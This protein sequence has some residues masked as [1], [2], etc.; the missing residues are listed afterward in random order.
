MQSKLTTD[1]ETVIVSLCSYGVACRFHGEIV[2]MGHSIY[3]EK[4]LAKLRE[5][6][7]VLP[8]CGEIMGGLPIPRPPCNVVKDKD[9]EL[10]VIG[11]YNNL[12]Y[13]IPYFKGADEVLRLAKIYNVKRAYLLDKSPMCGKGY[14]ILARK[15]EEN[16]IR[17][18]KI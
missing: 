11:R 4:K 16:G 13:T 8:L 1:K 15:L 2:K 3:K 7:Y 10:K 9:G 6:Y 5:Q 14:G 18:E 12:D 17:V